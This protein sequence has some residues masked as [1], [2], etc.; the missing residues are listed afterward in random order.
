MAQ[1]KEKANEFIGKFKQSRRKLTERPLRNTLADTANRAT[2]RRRNTTDLAFQSPN[3]SR[4]IGNRNES[5]FKFKSI[6]TS[7]FLRSKKFQ[8]IVLPIAIVIFVGCYGYY[9]YFYSIGSLFTA[10]IKYKYITISESETVIATTEDVNASVKAVLL[11]AEESA[12]TY[13]DATGEKATG[14]RARGSVSI[15]NP[16]T[17]IKVIKAGTIL[18]CTSNIC[19]SLNY[20]TDQDL[21]LGPGG[22][23]EV[24][25]TASDIGEN[26][27]LAP[28]AGKFKV[29]NYDQTKDVFASNIK[30]LAGGTPKK[31]IKVVR[32][33]DIKK[34]EENGMK[35]IGNRLLE[36][37]K[38]DPANVSDFI[39]AENTLAVEKIS[40]EPDIAEGEEADIVNVTVRVRG[41]VQAFKKDQLSGIV[42]EM[43]RKT[44]PEGY[45]L[46]EKYTNYSS[47][48]TNADANGMSIT[49]TLNTIARPEI[50]V[51]QLKKDLAGKSYTKADQILS[52]I[53]NTTGY[54]HSF[55]PTTLPKF[56]W[57]IPK[58]L[59]RVQIKLIA[60]E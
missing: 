4:T 25:V 6:F 34:A 58:S 14:E 59:N 54:T 3:N 29:G 50:N 38:T 10:T 53:P 31:I 5:S 15:F 22:S 56:F 35:D 46:D 28:G 26:Y 47:K 13:V 17:E 45:Y 1:I 11:P 20:T 48:V 39:L 18:S 57:K 23:D 52:A 42:D 36:K 21:N 2:V 37:I 55:K 51:D 27:N 24:N 44:V 7:E 19:N 41:T 12:T 9:W 16:T 60:E 8:Y 49:V 43:K 33:E 32:A 30:A 40:A